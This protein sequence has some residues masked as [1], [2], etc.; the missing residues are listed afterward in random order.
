M[1]DGPPFDAI[2]FRRWNSAGKS[3]VAA[4][5]EAILEK[6]SQD[7]F[8]PMRVLEADLRQ[9]ERLL[10]KEKIAGDPVFVIWRTDGVRHG[11]LWELFEPKPGDRRSYGR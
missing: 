11:I 6:M 1:T 7:M 8:A 4:I 10:E 9:C 5:R 2:A 3:W